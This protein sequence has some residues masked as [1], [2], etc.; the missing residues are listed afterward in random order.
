M[1]REGGTCCSSRG[2]GKS[3]SRSTDCMVSN[4]ALLLLPP[5]FT[6]PPV[7]T[8]PLSTSTP[9]AFTSSTVDIVG[10][11]VAILS[12]MGG[13]GGGPRAGARTWAWALPP[14]M[15]RQP[16]S[17]MTFNIPIVANTL[18]VDVIIIMVRAIVGA[19]V[20]A[21]IRAR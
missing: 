8:G 15:N 7:S 11:V 1:D 6:L 14:T 21:M 18:V 20:R 16:R 2:S 4:V 9:I 17:A 12:P 5:L 10:V 3:A 19:R 13:F